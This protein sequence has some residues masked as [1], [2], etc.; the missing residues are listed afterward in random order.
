MVAKFRPDQPKTSGYSRMADVLRDHFMPHLSGCEWK[1]LC[2]IDRKIAGWS[3]PTAS[4]SYRTFLHGQPGLDEG[5]GVSRPRLAEALFV[6]EAI[7]IL[8]RFQ[9]KS[10][11]G[12]A[13]VAV[14]RINYDCP[15]EGLRERIATARSGYKTEPIPD[16][17]TG[18]KTEPDQLQNVTTPPCLER[19]QNLT[20]SH[21]RHIC[22]K[23]QQPPGLSGSKGGQASSAPAPPADSATTSTLGPAGLP[24][25]AVPP[26]A[27]AVGGDPQTPVYIS[28]PEPGPEEGAAS[29]QESGDGC[30]TPADDEAIAQASR[31]MDEKEIARY[32]AFVIKARKESL[33]NEASRLAG[34]SAPPSPPEGQRRGLEGDVCEEDR[35]ILKYDPWAAQDRDSGLSPI[36]TVL[37]DCFVAGEQKSRSG[38]GRSSILELSSLGIADDQA[39]ELLARWGEGKVSGWITKAKT[40]RDPAAYL[41]TL[42]RIEARKKSPTGV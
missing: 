39:R 3:K 24:P 16:E 36:K 11:G 12:R 2:Y 31:W 20:L 4:I 30:L 32:R 25:A 22:H 23:Q 5:A 13:Q 35:P 27:V 8:Q 9:S 18:Y 34:G 6:L 19:L 14:Y 37:Q 17:P 1:V 7:G 10:K 15:V 40:K 21:E 42:S 33:E 26:A 38:F 41:V 29:R 28:P